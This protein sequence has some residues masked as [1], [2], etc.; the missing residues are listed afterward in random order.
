MVNNEFECASYEHPEIQSFRETPGITIFLLAKL[1]YD[2]KSN[3]DKK[4]LPQ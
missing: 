4:T 3:R 2:V 1:A